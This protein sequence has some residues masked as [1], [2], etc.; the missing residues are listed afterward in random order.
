MNARQ[1]GYNVH[2]F[3]LLLNRSLSPSRLVR[4]F[5]FTIFSFFY[6]EQA[7]SATR[8]KL[9]SELGEGGIKR[10]TFRKGNFRDMPDGLG[11]MSVQLVV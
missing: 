2:R 1:I 3:S 8:R 10:T 6:Q 4:F 9:Q 11:P 5:F 7:L